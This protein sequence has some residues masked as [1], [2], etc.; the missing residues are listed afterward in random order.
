MQ[1]RA[2]TIERRIVARHI[3]HIQIINETDKENEINGLA[4]DKFIMYYLI[5]IYVF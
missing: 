1:T 5:F 2:Q 4:M 3:A